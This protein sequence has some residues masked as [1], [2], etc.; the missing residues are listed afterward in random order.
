MVRIH[1]NETVSLPSQHNG[2]RDNDTA[3]P[4]NMTQYVVGHS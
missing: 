4:V 3:R 1:V 2:S